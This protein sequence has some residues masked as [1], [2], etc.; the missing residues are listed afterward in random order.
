MFQETFSTYL[1]SE[2][3][4]KDFKLKPYMQNFLSIFNNFPKK[5]IKEK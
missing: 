4:H 5:W 2:E 1:K 3:I